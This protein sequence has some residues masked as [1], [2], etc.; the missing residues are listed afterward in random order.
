LFFL[1][2]VDLAFRA[3]LLC[4][5]FRRCARSFSF[6]SP[7]TAPSLATATFPRFSFLLLLLL[8]LILRDQQSFREFVSQCLEKDPAQRPSV[9]VCGDV[10]CFLP[11]FFLKKS[12]VQVLLQHKLI[13]GAKKTSTLK[14][15]ITRYDKYAEV[16]PDSDSEEGRSGRGGGSEV[17]NFSFVLIFLF[18]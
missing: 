13:R 16:V 1:L 8:W 14:Q 2:F 12:V 6:P 4:T 7:T 9:K 5:A 17:K 18:C 3:N 15:L 11:F 10:L